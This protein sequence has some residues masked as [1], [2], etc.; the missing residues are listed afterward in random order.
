MYVVLWLSFSVRLESYVI[1]YIY[2]FRVFSP[3]F[4]PSLL[5][6]P[7]F[8]PLFLS[9]LLFFLVTFDEV[10]LSLLHFGMSMEAQSEMMR[11]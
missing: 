9:S 11:V 4:S 3:P 2:L 10:L 5:N 8:L 7:S 1:I 6:V